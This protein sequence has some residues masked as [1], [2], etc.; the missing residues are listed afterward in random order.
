M[1][2]F[3]LF[4]ISIGWLVSCFLSWLIGYLTG[5]KDGEP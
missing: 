5:K 3:E 2:D 4:G 1:S